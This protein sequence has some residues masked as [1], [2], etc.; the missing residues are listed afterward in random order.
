VSS[1]EV[2]E[3]P[4]PGPLRVPL[5]KKGKKIKGKQFAGL[6]LSSGAADTRTAASAVK[7]KKEKKIFFQDQRKF[8]TG[9]ALVRFRCKDTRDTHIV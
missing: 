6:V 3:L 1:R 5:K 7:R 8:A 4:I 9:S 2:Q